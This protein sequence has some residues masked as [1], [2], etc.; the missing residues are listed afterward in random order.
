MTSCHWPRTKSGQD[1]G[2]SINWKLSSAYTQSTRQEKNL[3]IFSIHTNKLQTFSAQSDT[4][5]FISF[6]LDLDSNLNLDWF[7]LLF[8]ALFCWSDWQCVS[9]STLSALIRHFKHWSSNIGQ[10]A[11][12]NKT[13]HVGVRHFGVCS[14]LERLWESAS[15]EGEL[16][17]ECPPVAVE[18][19]LR[20]YHVQIHEVDICIGSKIG[21]N[22]V[23]LASL[24]CKTCAE[25]AFEFRDV[26]TG[27]CNH[28]SSETIAK[29]YCGAAQNVLPK[30]KDNA[31]KIIVLV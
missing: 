29:N 28:R 17:L 18:G 22:F 7:V 1:E 23:W 16:P 11:K 27:S 25:T 20:T 5:M 2:K 21:L 10:T 8:I 13:S 31:K 15:Y 6:F 12:V 14:T 9:Y 4:E 24:N 26:T 19:S 30:R 3:L